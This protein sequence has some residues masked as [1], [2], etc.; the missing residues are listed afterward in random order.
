MPQVVAI[1]LKDAIQPT[2]G[3]RQQWVGYEVDDKLGNEGGVGR[4]TIVWAIKLIDKK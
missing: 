2:K 1:Q 3:W 4:Y